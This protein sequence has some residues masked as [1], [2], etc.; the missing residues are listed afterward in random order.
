M[1][2]ALLVA[3]IVRSDPTVAIW[4]QPLG[5]VVAPVATTALNAGTYVAVPL[6]A[7]VSVG[8]TELAIEATVYTYRNKQNSAFTGG[9]LSIGPVLHTGDLALG[10][11]MLVPKLGFDVMHEFVDNRTG[12]SLLPGVDF[13]WQRTFGRLYLAVV[14]GVSA[15]WS[16]ADGDA[17]EGPGLNPTLPTKPGP[18]VGVNLNLLRLGGAF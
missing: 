15:G 13:G 11:F 16:F 10:G 12:L 17:I 8:P 4:A 18:V 2:L 9:M 6:G 5:L 1:F 7:N 14:M 3:T